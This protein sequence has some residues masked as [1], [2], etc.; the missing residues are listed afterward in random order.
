MN[1]GDVVYEPVKRFV[2]VHADIAEVA[3]VEGDLQAGFAGGVEDV[4][5]VLD[6]TDE[7]AGRPAPVLEGHGHAV[8]LGKRHSFGQANAELLAPL[9]RAETVGDAA[10]HN[11]AALDLCKPIEQ[12]PELLLTRRRCVGP[13]GDQVERGVAAR[14]AHPRFLQRLDG[15]EDVPVGVQPVP[16]SE[17]QVLHAK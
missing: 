15:S 2:A 3:Y 5:K 10:Q 7:L 6:R 16:V 11:G 8:L 17:I 14:D 4:F 9:R 12:L 13:S 1:V